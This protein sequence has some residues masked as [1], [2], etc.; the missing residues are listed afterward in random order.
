MSDTKQP[1]DA[2][3]DL[4]DDTPMTCPLNRGDDDEICESCQ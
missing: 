4:D 1:E 3:L 2:G